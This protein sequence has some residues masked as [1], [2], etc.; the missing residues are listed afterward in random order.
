[1]VPTLRG[2][3]HKIQVL[4]GDVLKEMLQQ[5]FG[6]EM[7]DQGDTDPLIHKTHKAPHHRGGSSQKG[8]I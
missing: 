7:G 8:K 2:G 6:E 3:V 4:V 5:I 1:M